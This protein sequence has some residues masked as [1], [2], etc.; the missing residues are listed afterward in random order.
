MKAIL[1]MKPLNLNRRAVL[2]DF[3]QFIYKGGSADAECTNYFRQFN[4]S[5]AQTVIWTVFSK[6]KVSLKSKSETRH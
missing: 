1:V 4:F 6:F 2:L 5:P 3:T